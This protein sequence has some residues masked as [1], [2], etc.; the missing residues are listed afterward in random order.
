MVPHHC[1][2]QQSSVKLLSLCVVLNSLQWDEVGCW[3][4]GNRHKLER[5]KFWLCERKIFLQWRWPT[6]GTGCPGK[7]WHLHPWSCSKPAGQGSTALSRRLGWNP[8][9]PLPTPVSLQTVMVQPIRYFCHWLKE[10]EKCWWSTASAISVCQQQPRSHMEVGFFWQ[11]IGFPSL[12]SLST[13]SAI[14]NCII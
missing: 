10:R 12:L 14:C 2:L 9:R 6:C 3:R 4:R 1:V 11:K 7:A 13:H 8:C 5:G